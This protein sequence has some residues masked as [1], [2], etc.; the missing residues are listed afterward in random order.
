[1][2]RQLAQIFESRGRQDLSRI[3]LESRKMQ[4]L[5]W[6]NG[7]GGYNDEKDFRSLFKGLRAAWA[8]NDTDEELPSHE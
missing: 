4:R 5:A 7:E 6:V 3:V 8:D 2:Q 1:M